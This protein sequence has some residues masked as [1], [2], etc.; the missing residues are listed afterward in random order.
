MNFNICL[1]NRLIVLLAVFAFVLINFWNSAVAQS[2]RRSSPASGQKFRL[3]KANSATETEVRQAYLQSMAAES[4]KFDDHKTVFNWITA[5][6]G[7]EKWRKIKWRHDLWDARIESAKT[8]KP[9]FIWAMNGDPLGC[10]WNNGVS[11]RE[12]VF[13]DDRIIESLNKDF[14]PVVDNVS[15]SQIREDA[16]GEFFRKIA[17]QGHYRGRTIPT[18]TRQGLYTATADGK[19]LVSVNSTQV[20]R[21]QRLLNDATRI[22]RKTS[23]AERSPKFKKKVETDPKYSRSPPADGL[24]LLSM[25]RDLPRD[26]KAK[27]TDLTAKNVDHVWIKKEEMLAMVPDDPSK[28]QLV[29]MPEAVAER[30]A[31]FHMIDSVR[32]QTNPFDEDQIEIKDVGLKVMK[33][34][35]DSIKFVVYGRSSADRPPSKKTNPYTGFRI[36]KSSGNDLVWSGAVVFDRKQKRFTRFDLLAV[37]E[38]WGGSL[39][40]FR[41]TDLNRAP[42]GFAFQII[43]NVDDNPTPPSYLAYYNF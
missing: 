42:I 25:I 10:V 26:A 43:P 32:G 15:H 17:E 7:K 35:D 23:T 11:G 12:S 6:S 28:G 5:T 13:S 19:L 21:V 18:D 34:S 8:G 33:V 37:G 2:T 9:I 20:G 39:Y 40:N 27:S 24:Y 38:R 31:R 30:L 36:T 41:D 3:P 1:R 4:V 22:W 14:I 16:H 29:P